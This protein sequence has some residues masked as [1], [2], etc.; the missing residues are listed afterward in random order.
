LEDADP[1]EKVTIIPRCRALGATFALPERE[2]YSYGRR[3]LAATM[4]VLCGGRIAEQRKTGD[5][6]SGAEDDIRKLTELADRMVRTWGMSDEIGFVRVATD[7][8]EERLLIDRGYSEQTARQ[9]DQEIKRLVSEAYH[10]A[11]QLID[12]YWETVEAI[13]EAL[14]E[15][16]TLTAKEIEQLIPERNSQKA[17][18]HPPLRASAE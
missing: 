11:Q 1:V 13:A 4:R 6:S 2:R 14:L 15:H 12:Q 3:Y 17:M 16:E 8:G 5:V 9:V 7:A 10:D 18:Q